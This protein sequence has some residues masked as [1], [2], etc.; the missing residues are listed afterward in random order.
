MP[1]RSQRR[2]TPGELVRYVREALGMTQPELAE[3]FGLSEQ[4]IRRYER[5]GAA[6]IVRLALIGL[7]VTLG[8]PYGILWPER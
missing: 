8:K 3:A 6:R 1:S 7:L 2:T 4:T 5:I